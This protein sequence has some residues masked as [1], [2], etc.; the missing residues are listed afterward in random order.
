[1]TDIINIDTEAEAMIEAVLGN[2]QMGY[3]ADVEDIFS[4]HPQT[5]GRQYSADPPRFPKPIFNGSRRA[6]TRATLKG[7]LVRRMTTTK[8][9]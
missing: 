2:R 1:M 9:A 6:W 7:E 5:T 3:I 4:Q 8:A